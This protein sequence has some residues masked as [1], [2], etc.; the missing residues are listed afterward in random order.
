MEETN[1]NQPADSGLSAELISDFQ[2]EYASTGQRFLNF[3][4][5]FLLLRFGLSL[6]TGIGVLIILGLIAPEFMQGLIDN[7]RS[8]GTF[9]VEYLIITINTLLY[10][11]ICEKAFR[12]YTLGKLITG[13]RAIRIDGGELTFKDAFLRSLSRVVP[14]EVLSGFGGHPWHDTWTNT[15]VIKTR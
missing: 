1:Y 15:M 2:Y 3:F 7:P 12:G 13:T 9:L 14:F 6:L 4:I 11:T 8:F 10:Y 5:D